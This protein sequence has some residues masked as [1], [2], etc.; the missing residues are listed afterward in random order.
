MCTYIILPKT[1]DGPVIGYAV[2]D[3]VEWLEATMESGPTPLPQYPENGIYALGTGAGVYEYELESQEIFPRPQLDQPESLS[4][5]EQFMKKYAHFSGQPNQSGFMDLRSLETLAGEW[6]VGDS[7][8]WYPGDDGITFNTYGGCQSPKL[9]R[10]CDQSH[11]QWK[12]Y[13]KRMSRMS[14]IVEDHRDRLGVDVAW[15]MLLD[16]TPGGEV[17]QHIDTRPPGISFVTLRNYVLAPAMGRYWVR[18]VAEGKAPDEVDPV[19]MRFDPWPCGT[20]KQGNING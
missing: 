7:D 8:V 14:Q 10:Y 15:K 20:G 17:C 5:I 9:R 11:P 13:D 16:R 19:E 4:D 18:T 1:S 6:S 3:A 2:D 12:Y